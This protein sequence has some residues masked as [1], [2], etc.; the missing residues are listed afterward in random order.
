MV[1]VF[2]LIAVPDGSALTGI[3]TACREVKAVSRASNRRRGPAELSLVHPQSL[4]PPGTHIPRHPHPAGLGGD[5]RGCGHLH[6][7][8]PYAEPPRANAAPA[9]RTVRI[10][11]IGRGCRVAVA[12]CA[13]DHDDAFRWPH[14]PNIDNSHRTKSIAVTTAGSSGSSPSARESLRARCHPC[15]VGRKPVII[16]SHPSLLALADGLIHECGLPV[17][18]YWGQ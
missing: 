7:E 16:G 3:V 6:G 14:R 2:G 11:S 13:C 18:A 12:A 10:P 8:G 5:E 1:A 15:Q 4:R 17:G 9:K